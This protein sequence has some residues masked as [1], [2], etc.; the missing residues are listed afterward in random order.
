MNNS[1]LRWILP[2]QEPV[3]IKPAEAQLNTAP[4]LTEDPPTPQPN[5]WWINGSERRLKVVI[6]EKVWFTPLTLEEGG[7]A[8][9]SQFAIDFYISFVL[10]LAL[11]FGI[12]FETPIVVFFLAWSG[13]VS[14]KS[15]GHARRYVILG[16]VVGAAVLTPPDVISQVLLAGPMYMLFEI[17]LLIGR[18][19]E[20]K[21]AEKT[22]D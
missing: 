4:I 10:M 5:S 3:G 2:T 11:G 12:A 20:K 22:G 19:V 17:G 6:G 16:I 21:A 1:Y 13:L 8:V 15:M 9:H 14:T 7:S 18:I